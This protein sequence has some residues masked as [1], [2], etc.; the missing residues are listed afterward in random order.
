MEGFRSFEAVDWSAFLKY[1]RAR[2]WN[3]RASE[4]F[5]VLAKPPM[6][7][8]SRSIEI[9]YQLL[10]GFLPGRAQKKSSPT[11]KKAAKNKN[12]PREYRNILTIQS[13]FMR[14][15]SLTSRRR[16]GRGPRRR[17]RSAKPATASKQS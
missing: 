12:I 6:G 14:F 1:F 4:E 5:F 2:I 13:Q 9:K 10:L 16:A 11:D 17:A 3:I 15:F 8:E 7:A